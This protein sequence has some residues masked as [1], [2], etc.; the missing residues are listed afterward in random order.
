M[1]KV[2]NAIVNVG[3]DSIGNKG[4]IT[5]HKISFLTKFK[6]FIDTKYPKWRFVTIYDKETREKLDVWKR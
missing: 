4:F 1:A 2:Y 6:S 5:Y 3:D